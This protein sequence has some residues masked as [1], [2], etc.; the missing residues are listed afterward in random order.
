MTYFSFI[1]RNEAYFF[2]KGYKKTNS[3]QE[4]NCYGEAVANV[5]KP[6]DKEYEIE[7]NDDHTT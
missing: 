5:E 4:N 3:P 1:S 2:G 6:F 7:V